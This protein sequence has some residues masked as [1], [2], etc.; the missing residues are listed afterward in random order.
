LPTLPLSLRYHLVMLPRHLASL[1]N[2]SDAPALTPDGRKVFPNDLFL[3]HKVIP[4]ARISALPFLH[5]PYAS[6]QHKGIALPFE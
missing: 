4:P 2:S 6:R 1:G 3:I 5:T